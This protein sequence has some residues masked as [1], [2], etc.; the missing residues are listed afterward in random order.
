[1]INGGLGFDLSGDTGSNIMIAYCAV[2]GVIFL[3][4]VVVVVFGE[5][6]RKRGARRERDQGKLEMTSSPDEERSAV[7]GRT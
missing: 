5:V 6:K 4:Y 7:F 1:M 2:A 3:M